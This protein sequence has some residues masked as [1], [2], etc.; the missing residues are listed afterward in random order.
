MV[1]VVTSQEGNMLRSTNLLLVYP[2]F[3]VAVMSYVLA[4]L[5]VGV[6]K[7]LWVLD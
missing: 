4:S 7:R 5:T 2:A 1:V 3:H 6:T